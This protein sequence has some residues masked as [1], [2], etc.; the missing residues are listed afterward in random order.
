MQGVVHLVGGRYP[1][2]VLVHHGP[3][4][5]AKDGGAYAGGPHPQ[6]IREAS[7]HLLREVASA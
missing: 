7:L 4:G 2:W 3:A 1:K 5:E 6:L